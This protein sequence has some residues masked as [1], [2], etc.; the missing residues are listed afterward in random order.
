MSQPPLS[1]SLP[2]SSVPTSSTAEQK[3]EEEVIHPGQHHDHPSL[4]VC[5]R[6]KTGSATTAT[7]PKTAPR[8]KPSAR[9]LCGPSFPNTS[10]RRYMSETTAYEIGVDEAGRG[11][12]FGR[13]YVAGV[14]LPK[15]DNTECF[16]PGHSPDL[17]FVHSWM[18]DSK[19]IKAHA[20]MQALSEYIQRH[21]IAFHIAY[22]EPETIDRRNILQATVDCMQECVREIARQIGDTL[23]ATG[24]PVRESLALVDG[25]YFRPVGFFNETTNELLYI[26]H[27]TV[28]QGDASFTSIAAASILAKCARDN[29]VLELCQQYPV[30]QE[31]YGLTTNMGY[32]TATH[33]EG[34]R[35]FGATQWHRQSFRP[36]QTVPL[37]PIPEIPPKVGPT[38]P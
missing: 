14:V 8:P 26:P 20:K 6:R 2:L 10:L 4:P 15:K 11:P 36:C 30:L 28:E 27:Q 19:Q 7:Q 37:C 33:M 18:K 35:T 3:V 12:L 1:L 13:V 25:S 29:Y 38:D 23:P 32:G 24:F 17:G 22:A 5:K 16:D 21:A 9:S 31:R 34:L